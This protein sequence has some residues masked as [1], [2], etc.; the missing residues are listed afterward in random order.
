MA[1]S[2]KLEQEH[3]EDLRL[4]EQGFWSKKGLELEYGGSLKN[5][6]GSFSSSSD[7]SPGKISRC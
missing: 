1:E 2:E 7:K 4:L 6:I 3:V 5:S